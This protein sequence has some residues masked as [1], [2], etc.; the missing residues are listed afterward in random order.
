M[1]LLG[2]KT[3]SK[4]K[5]MVESSDALKSSEKENKYSIFA[6]LNETAY[7]KD[8]Q[9]YVVVNPFVY[10]SE[11]NNIIVSDTKEVKLGTTTSTWRVTDAIENSMIDSVT[12]KRVV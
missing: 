1:K 8:I 7:N 12:I 6:V 4:D 10:V 9:K 3:K 11:G 2:K 5:P